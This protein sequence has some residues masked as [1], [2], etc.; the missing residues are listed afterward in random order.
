MI[1]ETLLKG[2]PEELFFISLDA[3]IKRDGTQC[4]M[5]IVNN[6]TNKTTFFTTLTI[7]GE[8]KNGT[9]TIYTIRLL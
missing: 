9:E 8:S 7:R 3:L 2:T 5:T 1:V 6:I 4:E